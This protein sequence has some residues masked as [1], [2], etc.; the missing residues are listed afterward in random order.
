MV[1]K[2]KSQSAYTGL[3]RID[4]TAPQSEAYQENRNLVLNDG[5]KAES[6]PELEILTDEVKCSHG[7]TVG[8]LDP[9][10]L[11]YLMSSGLTR[12]EATRLIQRG[13]VEP[14]LSKLPD[15]L[16]ERLRSHVEERV[17]HL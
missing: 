16:Q 6:I 8:T 1:L 12:S 15:G 13:F 14:T 7:A 4:E 3:I 10:H 17:R 11:F 2:D 5:A 9:Q